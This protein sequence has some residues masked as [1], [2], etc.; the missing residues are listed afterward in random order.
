MGLKSNNGR[1]SKPFRKEISNKRF[2]NEK[3]TNYL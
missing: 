1:T 2:I 3:N